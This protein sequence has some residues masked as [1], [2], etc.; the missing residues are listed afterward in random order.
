MGLPSDARD[1]WAAKRQ[2]FL[3]PSPHEYINNSS[4][5]QLTFEEEKAVRAKRCSDEGVR[6]GL[7]AA[8][9]ACVASTIPTLTV[10][11]VVPWAKANLNYVAQALIISAASIASYFIVAEK[12]ILKCSRQNTIKQYKDLQ[13]E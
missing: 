3:I 5:R 2:S 8:G 13:S 10:V 4:Q 1:F 7:K 12:T 6:E 11:R 9:I